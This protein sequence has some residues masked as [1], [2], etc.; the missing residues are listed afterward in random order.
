MYES[1]ELMREVSGVVEQRLT[2]DLRKQ[3]TGFLLPQT[4]IARGTCEK[5][6]E[7]WSGCFND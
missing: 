6:M 7:M 5:I 1:V 2:P 3:E 4:S